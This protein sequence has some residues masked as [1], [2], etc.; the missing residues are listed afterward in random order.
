MPRL[1]PDGPLGYKPDPIDWANKADQTAMF[2]AIGYVVVSVGL[3]F[4]NTRREAV[5]GE[6]GGDGV[7]PSRGKWRCR[8]PSS[9]AEYRTQM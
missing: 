7:Q 8:P 2:A 3:F 5:Y 6:S 1:T 9:F 4:F